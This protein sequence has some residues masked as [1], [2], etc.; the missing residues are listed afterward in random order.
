ME[1]RDITFVHTCEDW[2]MVA[3]LFTTLGRFHINFPT[4]IVKTMQNGLYTQF[5]WRSVTTV[6]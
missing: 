1:S 3:R 2:N 6:L 4:E 5:T